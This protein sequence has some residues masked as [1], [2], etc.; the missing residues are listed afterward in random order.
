MN[1]VCTTIEKAP[2]SFRNSGEIE[3]VVYREDCPRFKSDLSQSSF[4]RNV[5]LLRLLP[6]SV[7]KFLSGANR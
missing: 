6:Y 4:I 7:Y 2:G 5:Q 1:C 3:P